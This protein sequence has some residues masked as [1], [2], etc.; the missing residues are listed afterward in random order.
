MLFGPTAKLVNSDLMAKPYGTFWVSEFGASGSAVTTTGTVSASSNQ[1][2]VASVATF[3]VG[4]GIYI[5]G[6]GAAGANLVTTISG[7][8]GNV[9]TLAAAASTAVSN[10]RV[11]HD[12]TVAIQTALNRLTTIYVLTLIFDN[13]FYRVNGPLQSTNSIL[14]IP[15]STFFTGNPRTLRLIGQDN[16]IAAVTVTP[17]SQGTIIQ[18]DRV[19]NDA[20]S[21]IFAANLYTSGPSFPAII[22]A[23]NLLT[24]DIK[25]MTFRTYDNPNLSALDLAM[26][27]NV[28]LENVNIDTGVSPE[29]N[30]DWGGSVVEASEPTHG[31]FG[32]R[33]PRASTVVQTANV[34]VACYSIGV[35]YAD[36]WISINTYIIRCKTGCFTRGHD[37]PITG[38]ILIVQCPTGFHIEGNALG[39]PGF[40]NLNVRWEID[41]RTAPPAPYWWGNI[42]NRYIYDPTN[43]LFGKLLY[44][45]VQGY[46]PGVGGAITV[47]GTTALTKTNVL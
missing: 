45:V 36:L 41:P 31:T 9:I 47:T 2:T 1:L 14:N 19:G 35:W 23:T 21:S 27:W 16:P 30:I 40:A 28:L 44:F 18:S 24:I 46:I 12:D 15:F 42:P 6:A 17:Q 33:L 29:G 3:A 20:N 39:R 10:A 26:C 43:V 32:L 34:S 25:G 4:Q 38:N 13:G 11:Q 37:Y 8:N 22:N 5:A 7:I